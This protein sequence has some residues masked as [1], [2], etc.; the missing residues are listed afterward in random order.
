M[1]EENEPMELI[2]V[3]PECGSN[4]L[5]AWGGPG[6]LEITHVYDDGVLS[7]DAFEPEEISNYHCRE[8]GYKIKFDGDEDIVEWLLN[9]CY[10]DIGNDDENQ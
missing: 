3:C 7:W 2:F 10:R 4:S 6:P 5:W 8:C 9:N 1:D